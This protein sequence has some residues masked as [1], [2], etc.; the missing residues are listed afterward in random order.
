MMLIDNVIFNSRGIPGNHHI[1]WVFLKY[2]GDIWDYQNKFICWS[3]SF[4]RQPYFKHVKFEIVMKT[5]LLGIY[6]HRLQC[7]LPTADKA[8]SWK[9]LV[10]YITG[11]FYSHWGIHACL[12]NL[13]RKNFHVG[14]LGTTTG[15]SFTA[16]VELLPTANPLP[17]LPLSPPNFKPFL[18]VSV[19]L[20]HHEN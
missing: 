17:S 6:W 13:H 1:F 10:A 15:G 4:A 7:E 20:P 18:G 12:N 19:W 3:L 9:L 5:R 16:I 11:S 8:Y 2:L 14:L